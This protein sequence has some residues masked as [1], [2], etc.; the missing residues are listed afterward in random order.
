MI[1]SAEVGELE[2]FRSLLAGQEQA[3]LFADVFVRAYGTPEVTR[4]LLAR[5]PGSDG[6]HCF[7]A[8]D[9][10]TPA[11]TGAAG[12]EPLYL[13]QNYLSS[14]AADTSGTQA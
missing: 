2:A 9:D 4:P 1:P 14:A 7:L 6:W 10:K 11:A 3:N 12:F 8:F 13:R 5:I